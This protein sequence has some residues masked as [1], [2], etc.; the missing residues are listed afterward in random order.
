MVML[1]VDAD[2]RDSALPIIPRFERERR[3]G[4]SRAQP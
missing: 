2:A 3:D 4:Q 1:P